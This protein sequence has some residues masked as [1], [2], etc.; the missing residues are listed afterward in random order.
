[1]DL[2]DVAA[3][4]GKSRQITAEHGKNP[5][6]AEITGKRLATENRLASAPHHSPESL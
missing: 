4:T 3:I 2:K 1:M 6:I 5:Q